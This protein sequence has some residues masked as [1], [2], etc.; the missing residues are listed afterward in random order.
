MGAGNDVTT[1]VLEQA[2]KMFEPM[3]VPLHLSKEQIESQSLEELEDSLRN[4]DHAIEHPEAMGAAN[5]KIGLKLPYFISSSEQQIEIGILPLL[6]ERKRL[7]LERLRVLKGNRK[8]ATLRDLVQSVPDEELKQQLDQEIHQLETEG[9]RLREQSRQVEQ[10]QLVVQTKESTE[11]AKLQTELFERRSKVWQGF[12]ERES[13]ATIVGAF[14]LVVMALVLMVAM[15]YG[16]KSSEIVNNSFL[17]ILGYFF[18][19]ATNRATIEK[20]K[21]T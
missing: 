13:V 11:L 6:L 18:G 15:F 4:I 14:L 8:I 3:L 5:L 7:I 21:T 1:D 19:Q 17:V 12:L 9:Q 16:T 20:G 2:R 10:A